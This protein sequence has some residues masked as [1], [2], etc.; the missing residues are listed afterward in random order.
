MIFSD[1]NDNTEFSS[2]VSLSI[3]VAGDTKY[4]V[5]KINLECPAS[6]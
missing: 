2:W 6:Y 4:K 5:S 3:V 1:R